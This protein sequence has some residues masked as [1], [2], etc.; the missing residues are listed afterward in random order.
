MKV[1][2]LPFFMLAV[3][4]GGCGSSNSE[5]GDVKNI[6]IENASI[7]FNE[8]LYELGATQ[9]ISMVAQ[10][11]SIETSL[12]KVIEETTYRSQPA[13]LAQTTENNVTDNA[14]LFIDEGNKEQIMLGET[15]N[16]NEN[17][18]SYTPGTSMRFD[19]DK[20]DIHRQTITMIVNNSSGVDQEFVINISSEFQ[21]FENI[22]VP[23]GSFKTC[24]F[25][26]N[27][28][29]TL[30]DGSPADSKAI[31]WY[32]ANYGVEVQVSNDGT[33]S[34]LVEAELNGVKM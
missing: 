29:M 10:D 14:Y 24:K 13:L 12:T 28:S 16:A 2:V 3:S 20:G 6:D 30:P 34:K 32:A 22:T 7:C 19:V 33:I 1:T 5:S 27:Y 15:D 25:E 21:G 23:A 17:E 4:I 26:Q 9:T 8:D 18:L 11:G 31:I